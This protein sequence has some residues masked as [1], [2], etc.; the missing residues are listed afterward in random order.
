[1]T[2]FL[3]VASDVRRLR[4]YFLTQRLALTTDAAFASVYPAPA[5]CLV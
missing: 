2:A 4:Q 3:L 5:L 1:M